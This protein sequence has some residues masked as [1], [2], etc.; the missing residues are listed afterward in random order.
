MSERDHGQHEGGEQ[1]A[2]D[3][4]DISADLAYLVRRA[5]ERERAAEAAEAAQEQESARPQHHRRDPREN[6]KSSRDD[7]E[8]KEWLRA[9]GS[10]WG[11]PN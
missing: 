8:H 11:V 7:K 5:V 2:G 4:R 9:Y 10:S 3:S 1:G 6:L